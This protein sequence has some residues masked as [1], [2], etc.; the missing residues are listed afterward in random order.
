VK[1][2]DFALEM[3]R[4]IA[5]QRGLPDPVVETPVEEVQTDL[6]V[7][8]HLQWVWEAFARLSRTRLVNQAGP[9]PITVLELDAYCTL[10]G[11]WEETERRNLLHHITY[12][13]IDWLK[14]QYKK[15]NQSREETKREMEREQKKRQRNRGR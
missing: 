3:K 15:I 6:F 13:D 5:R 12:L 2:R 11:I 10:E 4:K 8:A 1:N 14:D 9:Q 7:A